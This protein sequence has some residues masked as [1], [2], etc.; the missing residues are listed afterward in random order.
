MAKSKKPSPSDEADRKAIQRAMARAAANPDDDLSG[1]LPATQRFQAQSR[2]ARVARAMEKATVAFVNFNVTCEA[3]TQRLKDK[4]A[5]L[6]AA[7]GIL[8]VP[9][10]VYP[11]KPKGRTKRG[12][13][14][15]KQ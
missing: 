1:F 10:P 2:I 9:A 7:K 5:A 8:V 4:Q 14:N 15:P 13:H 6:L 3:V 11:Y 12:W